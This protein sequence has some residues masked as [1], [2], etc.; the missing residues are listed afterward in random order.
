MRKLA[1]V[2]GIAAL[3]LLIGL[4]AGR[5]ACQPSAPRITIA[6]LGP[7]VTQLER[8]GEL[9]SLRV[10]VADILIGEDERFRGVWLIKG[11]ALLAIDMTRASVTDKDPVA[12]SATIRLPLPRVVSPRV[13]HERTRTWDVER[14]TWLPWKKG[15]QSLLRDEAM[16]HAQRL[17]EGAA[18]ND[19]TIREAKKQTETLLEG[20]Y[21]MVGWTVTVTWAE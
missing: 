5:F 13:D 21:Q 9:A 12:R 6:D 3:A 10:H 8:L 2:L 4:L 11:D 20:F 1:A 18:A 16:R 17:V 14:K 15:D 19:D 7:D